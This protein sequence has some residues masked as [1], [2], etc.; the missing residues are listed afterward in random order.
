MALSKTNKTLDNTLRKMNKRLT[1][2]VD[3][4]GFAT[5]YSQN[6]S[7]TM[8]TAALSIMQDLRRQGYNVGILRPG[9]I[10]QP[11]VTYI[12]EI[13][14]KPSNYGYIEKPAFIRSDVLN[15]VS[16]NVMNAALK[17]VENVGTIG[18]EV[19][20]VKKSLKQQGITPT[21]QEVSKELLRRYNSRF[22]L[23]QKMYEIYDEAYN[24]PNHFLYRWIRRMFPLTQA[25]GC[26]YYEDEINEKYN[27]FRFN[28]E[29][30][31]FP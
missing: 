31:P 10:K 3:G 4:Y 12:M 2:A 21:K 14:E 8:L 16:Q 5:E 7:A 23:I 25:N 1:D 29:G 20:A 13:K 22:A 30:L 26:Q 9:E 28:H 15:N 18:N 17:A 11:G 27:Y 19:K 24:D 6:M